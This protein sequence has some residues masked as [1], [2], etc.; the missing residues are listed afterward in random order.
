MEERSAPGSATED[1]ISFCALQGGVYVIRVL[2]RGSFANSVELK[3]LADQIADRAGPEGYR[4]IVDL[5]EC[6]TMDST[7]MGVLA[8]IGLRQKRD[9]NDELMTVVNANQQAFR[10]LQTLGLSHFMNVRAGSTESTVET[11]AADFQVAGKE[12]VSKLDRIIHM[13]EAHENLCDIDSGNAARFESVLKYL[14]ESL[15]RE[16]G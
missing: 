11:P 6:A 10:L 4:F 1:S 14:R 13:I 12:D 7:F 16:K 15:E 8:S 2:G 5:R 3:N 9:N